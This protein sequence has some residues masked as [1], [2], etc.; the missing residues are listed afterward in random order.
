[1]RAIDSTGKMSKPDREMLAAYM[2]R[3]LGETK[4]AAHDA[5]AGN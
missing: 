3:F 5:P 2:K 4:E 1:M